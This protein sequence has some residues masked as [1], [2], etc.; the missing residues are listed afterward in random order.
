MTVPVKINYFSDV[1][2][3]WAY[4]AQIRLDE[5][6]SNF[7]DKVVVEHHFVSVFGCTEDRI[8]GGWSGRGGYDGFSEHICV[9]A[10]KFPHIKVTPSVWSVCRPSTSA[11]SHLFLKSAQMTG[12][13]S[14]F[15]DYLWR[16]RN[17]F[18]ADARDVSLSS[19]LYAIAKEAGLNV[20]AIQKYIDD[21][22]AM[23]ALCRD[24]ELKEKLNIEGSPSYVLNNGR[25]KLYGNVGY[26][27][28]EANVREL[29]DT[30]GGEASW[31]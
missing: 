15:E 29:L 21:G 27:I 12:D 3:L 9:V 22:S 6:K 14:R 28:I 10:A 1:L 5:L 20:A 17:A 16:I 8:G 24:M 26:R 25:Q 19:E 4:A 13:I 18:F 23:A 11:M 30:P 2:C 7:S 31:C